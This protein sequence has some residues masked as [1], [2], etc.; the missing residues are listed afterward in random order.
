MG[1][2]ATVRGDLALALGP[3]RRGAG[4][5]RG[6]RRPAGWSPS[7]CHNLGNVTRDLG[8]LDAAAASLRCRPSAR[9]PSDD[10]RWSLAHL[11]EDVAVWLLARGPAGDAEAV[12]LLG[13][14]RA[15]ARGDRRAAVPA[16]RGRAGEALAPAREPHPGRR[17]S[18]AAAAAGRAASLDATV[19]RAG[20]CCTWL[21]EPVW[22]CSVCELFDGRQPSGSRTNAALGRLA[23]PGSPRAQPGGLEHVAHTC[24]HV[25]ACVAVR[26]RRHR[27]RPWLRSWSLL[28]ARS[29]V[30]PS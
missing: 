23:R 8:D 28:A 18:S 9:T 15:P 1:M 14:G 25:E 16:H 26:W 11:F 30:P 20:S 6:G 5:G 17:C 3:L 27:R 2:L 24:P 19:G 10:D 22:T 13:G 7:A 4:P 21:S 29:P 12:S